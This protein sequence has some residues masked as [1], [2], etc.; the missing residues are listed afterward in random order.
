MD[1]GTSATQ[2]LSI[3][4][5]DLDLGADALG[6]LSIA[7]PDDDPAA[8]RARLAD[9]GYAYFPGFFARD[10]VLAVRRAIVDDLARAGRLAPQ[11]DPMD[12]IP[13]AELAD[14][15]YFFTREGRARSVANQP[16]RRLLYDGRI[17]AFFAALLGGPVRHFDFTWLRTTAPGTGTWVHTDIIFMGRGTSNLWTAWVPYGDVP[18][19]MGGLAILERSHHDETIRDVY[20]R[21]DVDTF[22]E[23]LDQ[24][25]PGDHEWPNVDPVLSEDPAALQRS[26]GGRW[27][28]TDYRAG[29]LLV[30]GM[31]T[32]HGGLDN[33]TDRLRLTSDS[34]Y[35]LASDPIDERWIGPDPVGHSAA[36]KR[37]IVC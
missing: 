4:G 34:R 22:C 28:T 16:L 20:G 32:A 29:D 24:A 11:T 25:P 33:R 14:P 23:N 37:G 26:L 27:V 30:F 19:A 21:Q 7:D 10:D 12:A 5:R 18:R 31:H 3:N 9:D 36:G 2:P 17:I 35:Q 13:R 15:D 1:T 6:E 8:L